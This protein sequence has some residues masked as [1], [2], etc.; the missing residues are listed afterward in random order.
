MRAE[1]SEIADQY[2]GESAGVRLTYRYEV[3]I[4]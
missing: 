2:L 3:L 4:R 1:L